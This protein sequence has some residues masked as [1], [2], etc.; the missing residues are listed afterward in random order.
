MRN[1]VKSSAPV[2][3]RLGANG[4]IVIP[5]AIRE[6]AGLKPGE[7]VFLDVE[8]GVLKVESFSARIDRIQREFAPYSK[9]GV[10]ASDE[11]IRERREEVQREKEEMERDG[12]RQRLKEEGR[13]A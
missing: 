13:V 5:A 1:R 9:P 11:L 4:R 10:L 7:S 6:Q 3:I 12:E 8:D 2:K